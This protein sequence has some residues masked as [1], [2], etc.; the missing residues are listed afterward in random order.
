MKSR[1]GFLLLLFTCGLASA[2]TADCNALTH[3][4]LELSGF[5]QSIDRMAEL[6]ASDEFMRQMNG[7]QASE[8]FLEV[9]KPILL[10]EFNAALLRSEIQARVAAHCDPAQMTQTV[11]RMRTP[12]ITR[13]LALE[14]AGSTPEGQQKLKRY[15]NIAKTAPPTDDRIDA[16][17]AVEASAHA[18][19]F[20]TDTMMAVIRGMLTGVGAPAEIVSQ[21]QAHR[22]D[23]KAQMLNEIELSMS[24][25]YHGVTR[26]ELQQYAR[27]LSSQPL[28]GF[29]E[30][31]QRSFVE[32]VEE[33]SRA[34]GQ[35]LKKVMPQPP[36]AG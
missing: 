16:L 30:Q 22:K 12:F 34:M 17:D 1:F 13:M 18:S 24:V 8:E 26:P 31:V 33:R 19:D 29:F 10:K 2:Q 15:I 25:I 11:E 20:M 27:E 3:Q 36:H 5:N 21:V 35:D 7:R 28:K 9:F 32:I 4:A 14:A 23:M 6:L